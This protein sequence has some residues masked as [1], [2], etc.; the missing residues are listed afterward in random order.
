MAYQF[1]LLWT[2][3]LIYVLLISIVV[4]AMIARRHEHLRA[5]W[6]QFLRNRLGMFALAVLSVYIFI[7]LLD[8]IH[9]YPHVVNA[10]QTHQQQ[11]TTQ[12]R[13]L[14]DS[15]LSPLDTEYEKTY[16]APFA[17]TLYVKES[18]LN[19]AGEFIQYYP[20]LNYL[21]PKLNELNTEFYQRIGI[22]ITQGVVFSFTLLVLFILFTKFK[23]HHSYTTILKKFI[24]GQ[25]P[26]AWRVLF[27]TYLCLFIIM[28]VS[29]ELSR[30]FHILGTDQIGQDVFYQTL[31]SIR[32][33]L[34]IGT[35]TT[36]VMLPFAVILGMMA[37]YFG[38]YIDDIIQYVYTT[39]NSIPGVLLIA[40]AILS[41]Q[42]FMAN[43]PNLFP[44][45]AERADVRLLAL[46]VILG[47]TSWTG[48]CRLLRGEA[49]KLREM[50]YTAAAK[51]LGLSNFN[52]LIRHIL[53][54]VLHII[55]ISVVLDFSG[56]VLAEAVLSY[57]GVGVD[58]TT[59]SWG[60]MIN[61]ARLQLAREPVVWW[62]LLAAF[63]FMF[64]LV[65]AA[66]LFSDAIRDAFDPRIRQQ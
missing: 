52:I 18:K 42:I 63:I 57:V 36:L 47:I 45:I 23:T 22:G 13:S 43:H 66:N 6:R 14:L 39:L 24:S 41:L 8:S 4:F 9:F 25:T 26:Y 50:D 19:S 31:K 21:T 53:P 37:G 51:V 7:G 62:P 35:L 17:T 15:L 20:S 12:M 56:L 64:I 2:D 55:I 1:V 29:Y 5:P 33:G 27:F 49:L 40:A 58:P 60:N 10:Q 61:A 34:I 3:A 32:T 28:G 38:G 46:C 11:Q 54:N 44:S 65:L 48:L 59:H 16:S 30:I